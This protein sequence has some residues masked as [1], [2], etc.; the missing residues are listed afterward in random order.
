MAEEKGGRKKRLVKNPE[1]FRERALK[2]SQEEGKPAK[3][4][5]VRSA[6]S[7]VASPMARPFRAAARFLGRFRVFRLFGRLLA[8]RFIRN[9][10]QELKLVQWPNW[11]Q[12]RRLTFAVLVFAAAFGL[13]IAALDYGLSK[14]FKEILLK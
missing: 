6:G 11:Q 9:S 5:L 4:R 12:S 10:W 13:S 14:L 2:A 7:K 8:P 1:S 3:R